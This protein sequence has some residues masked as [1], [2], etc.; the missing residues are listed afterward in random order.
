M[1]E[2]NNIDE[3]I[4]NELIEAFRLW[5]DPKHTGEN[6]LLPVSKI[7][8]SAQ[9]EITSPP[10]LGF[11]SYGFGS[12]GTAFEASGCLD[13]TSLFPLN[14]ND[15]Y[16]EDMEVCFEKA[17]AKVLNGLEAV[18]NSIEFHKIPKQGPVVFILSIEDQVNKT[19]CQIHPDGQVELPPVK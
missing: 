3:Q 11:M 13:L 1:E 9:G 4:Q 16:A 6:P 8:F 12:E 2:G 10:D 5:A 19:L 14:D 7:I 18:A 15:Y 17:C